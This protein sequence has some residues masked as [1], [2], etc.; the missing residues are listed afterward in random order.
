MHSSRCL[1][2]CDEL[3]PGVTY[4]PRCARRLFGQ[5]E[6]PDLPVGWADLG[7]LADAAVR[8]GV[9]VPGT[10]PSLSLQLE[11]GGTGKARLTLM[12]RWGKPP[13]AGTP[14]MLRLEHACMRM[15]NVAK[16]D[17]VP[18]G[19][20]PLESGEMAYLYRRIDRDGNRKLGVEDMAQLLGRP[21]AGKYDGALEQVGGLLWSYS[22]TPQ[23]DVVR[24]FDLVLF[25][26]VT[27]N[28]EMHLKSFSLLR[29]LTGR[30]RLA[31][32]QGLTPSQV[33][34]PHAANQSAL[35]LN[36]RREGL[37]RDDFDR[38][39]GELRLTPKQRDNAYARL[40]AST[41]GMFE[42]LTRS[43]ATDAHK[44]ALREIM[45]QR[46]VLLGLASSHSPALAVRPAG[47]T[48]PLDLIDLES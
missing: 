11:R 16:I 25:G 34:E 32:V 4:H 26:F 33:L 48:G 10:R 5:S 22:S 18:C 31:P 23:L 24:L 41:A 29:D 42:T 36:G 45:Q 43:F 13:Y 47:R 28:A 6:A 7:D 19:L 44:H 14:G 37:T 40:G 9:A 27:G 17:T 38:L 3:A 15:A 1:I 8:D 35:T 12:G 46:L 20:I 30:L 21:I 2:C 39:A